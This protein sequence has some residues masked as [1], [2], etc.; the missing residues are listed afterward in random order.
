M[1]VAVLNGVNLDA[2]ADRDPAIYGG[3]SLAELETKIYAWASELGLTA[4]CLQT[5]HEGQFVDWC[6]GARS[7]ASGLIVN[8]GAWSHYSYAIR[9]ALEFAGCPVVEVHLSNIEE[10]EEW[11]RHSVIADVVTE[12]VIG[13]GPEGYRDALAYLAKHQ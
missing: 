6:H 3:L 9:D 11:R 4:R 1:Q 10:R 2:L 12:R 7:W 5:N 8:P 13:K